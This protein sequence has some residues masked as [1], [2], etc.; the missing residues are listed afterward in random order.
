MSGS[1][2]AAHLIVPSSIELD[3]GPNS[4]CDLDNRYQAAYN[5]IWG[6][7]SRGRA[8]CV[9]QTAEP[10]ENPVSHHQP[11]DL[12]IRP[13]PDWPDW[14]KSEFE[15]NQDNARVGT[16]LLSE[17][18]RVRV[19]HLA[20][21]PGER[22]PVHRHVLDYFWTALTPGR[23]RSHYHDGRTVEAEYRQGETQ[24]YRFGPGKFMMHDLENI[25]D[26]V[27]AFTTVEF[28]DSSNPPL[29]VG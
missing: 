26:S 25:G 23:A 17:S 9:L 15:T 29:T 27:L 19:W 16:Q 20:I 14:L 18:E 4:I 22:L 3:G 6:V 28:L 1:R 24:H 5:R 11:S 21:K 2:A 8:R 10:M 7:N 12:E 13:D